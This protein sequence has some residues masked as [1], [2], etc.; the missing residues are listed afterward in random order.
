MSAWEEGQFSRGSHHLEADGVSLDDIAAAVGTPTYVYSAPAIR[1]AVTRLQH[2]F[3]DRD[4]GL[5]YAVKANS[6]LAIL[7]LMQSLGTGFDIVSGGEL[8]RVLAAG[9]DPGTVVFSGVGKKIEE[10]DLA[11]KVGIE[12]F[13][14]ESAAELERVS[15]RAGLLNL[16]APISLRVNPDVD[17]GTHPYISTGLKQNKFGIPMHSALALYQQAAADPHL[18]VM[19]IDCHIGS[20]INTSAPLIEALRSV[21]ALVDE[22]RQQGIEVEHIDLGGGMGVSYHDEVALDLEA[23]AAEVQ[24]LMA[25]RPQRLLLEPGRCLVANAGVLLTRVEYLKPTADDAPNFAV[26]D[27]AMNDL[28][29]PALYQAWHDVQPVNLH[30]TGSPSRWD[31]VGPVCESGDFLARERDLCLAPGTLLAVASAGAYGMVQASNY[32]SRGRACEV[33][34]DAHQFRV[35]RRRETIQDQLRLE[36]ELP[37][38]AQ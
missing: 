37:G 25:R 11:L 1:A 33:L 29:R 14:I 26:V 15:G 28:I 6:N 4:I 5:R 23:Y 16:V 30:P 22:L 17:A 38:V 32:N 36:F 13:N 19:G 27:A 12:C 9:G 3:A 20:Q 24:Q 8:S 34:V 18:R 35:I 21:L 2:A 31:I 7:Q 10:I